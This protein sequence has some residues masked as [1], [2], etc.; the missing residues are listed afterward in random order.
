MSVCLGMLTVELMISA[1]H[2]LKE[3]RTVV[4]SLK[5]RIRN[6]HNVSIAESGPNNVWQRADLN[7]ACVADTQSTVEH[8]LR[9]VIHL[10]DDEPRCELI[11]PRIEYYA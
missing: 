3:R 9:S 5:E 11:C 4:N 6:R 1:S 2:S 8:I 10:I 7:I